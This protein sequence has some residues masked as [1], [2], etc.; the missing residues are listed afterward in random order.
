MSNVELITGG[1][2]TG[3][4]RR[5][6]DIKN[7]SDSDPGSKRLL[8]GE[9]PGDHLSGI[10]PTVGDELKGHTRLPDSAAASGSWRMLDRIGYNRLLNRNP[11]ELSGGEQAMLAV[12]S[13]LLM[14]PA[15]LCLDTVM[16][17]LSPTWRMEALGLLSE[18]DNRVHVADNRYRELVHMGFS[19]VEVKPPTEDHPVPFARPDF[20]LTL[21]IPPS[22]VN[23]E[24][25][26]IGFSYSRNNVF[27]NLSLRL[28][29]GRI[30]HL[31][32]QNGAGKSTLSKILSGVLKP[33]KGT[34][35]VNNERT[36]PY[37]KPGSVF[38]YSFQNPDD[39]LF[40]ATVGEQLRA[41]GPHG[42]E[43]LARV[44]QIIRIFG[45]TGLDTMHPADLPFTMRKR[46][47]LAST[48][49][50][51]RPWYIVD[52]PTLG[53]DDD[54]VTG[55]GRWLMAVVAKGSGVVV[56]S[57]APSF[58]RSLATETIDLSTLDPHGEQGHRQA[59]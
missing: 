8:I 14:E 52:E 21:P 29:P 17:Q 42:A 24:L 25:D 26:G 28:E 19:T 51:P 27:Q 47:A 6:L 4:S 20:G 55:F 38:G 56:I 39:Q 48:F 33:N 45:L 58:A 13:H 23:V 50:V 32:G 59:R 34:I 57:H 37:R 41:A 15:H 46:L 40:H 36:V 49:A 53:Q 44:E 5:L 43:Q 31:Q 3:K 12:V 22:K 9:L 18:I 10:F 30:Y 35:A 1:N 54:W 16:E 11:F 7:A 2:F